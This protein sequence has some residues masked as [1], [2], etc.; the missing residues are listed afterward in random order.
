M[1]DDLAVQGKNNRKHAK[2]VDRRRRMRYNTAITEERGKHHEED[3]RHD[4]HEHVH[5]LHVHAFVRSFFDGLS[6][7][8]MTRS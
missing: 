4:A 2:A 6:D 7:K 3:R 5:A 8:R 1:P